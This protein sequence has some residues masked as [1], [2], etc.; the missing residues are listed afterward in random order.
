M[1]TLDPASLGAFL[2]H[3]EKQRGI[4]ARSRDVRLAAIHAFFRYVALTEP[5]YS[6]LAQR[7]LAMPTKRLAR[8]SVEYLPGPG[9]RD[10]SLR[11]TK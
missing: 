4:C 8:R 1:E 7:V 10:C 2:N 9:S 6:A 11:R 3:L 5:A